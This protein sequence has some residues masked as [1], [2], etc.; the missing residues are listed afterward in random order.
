MPLPGDASTVAGER[1]MELHGR[2]RRYLVV[3]PPTPPIAIVL[4]L[5]GS[6]STPQGQRRLSGMDAL[7]RHGALIAYPAGGVRQGLGRRWDHAGDAP[8]L[9]ALIETL[10]R[11][12]PTAA[13]RVVL[14]GMSGGGRMACHLAS[15]RSDV[16]AAV[17]AVAGLRA[18]SPSTL[19]RPVPIFA[20][21]GTAD[22]VNP[23]GGGGRPEW[24]ES[25]PDAAAA[26]AAAN[27]LADAPD[28]SSGDTGY[29]RTTYGAGSAGEVTL[30]TIP[31][32]GHTWP[33]GHLG[34]LLTLL[35]GRTSRDIDASEAIWRF[36]AE[37]ATRAGGGD[38]TPA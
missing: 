4:S 25:V 7:T 29:V 26:W 16:V 2:N 8:F 24:Q 19:L 34:L 1:R 33:G 35:L 10:L 28:V 21:H 30:W 23:Y 37:H 22:R 13:R 3:E 20:L 6:G 11:E 36:G 32:G 15:V 12:Y 18:P 27:E 38:G 5:H 14:A 17:G 31:G 9:I